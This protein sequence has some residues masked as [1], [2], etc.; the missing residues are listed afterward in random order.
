VAAEQALVG[1][2]LTRE[3]AHRA[4]AVAFEDAAPRKASQFKMSLGPKCVAR[5]LMIAKE[6]S[7][8]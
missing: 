4:G 2:P 3:A 8:S 6:R 5:A 1:R 7:A